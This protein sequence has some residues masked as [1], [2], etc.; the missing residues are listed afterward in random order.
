MKK[1]QV[2][3]VMI[4]LLA[5][6]TGRGNK[7]ADMNGGEKID[8][9]TQVS[10]AVDSTAVS[11]VEDEPYISQDV[12]SSN[13][14]HGHS[15]SEAGDDRFDEIDHMMLLFMILMKPRIIY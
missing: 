13:F 2:I 7:D 10:T 3:F 4:V 9:N 15:I 6:S 12:N 14:N 1:K 8:T 5:L 11:V